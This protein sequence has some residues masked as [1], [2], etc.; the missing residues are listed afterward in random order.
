VL[1]ASRVTRQEGRDAWLSHDGEAGIPGLSGET[2]KCCFNVVVLRDVTKLSTPESMQA[3]C[4]ARLAAQ[5]AGEGPRWKI[6]E[7]GWRDPES[8]RYGYPEV[9]VRDVCV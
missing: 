1:R 2:S 9:I 7:E 4:G 6:H 8:Q 3:V 5:R